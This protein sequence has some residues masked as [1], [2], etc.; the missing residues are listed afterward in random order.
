MRTLKIALVITFFLAALTPAISTRVA[1]LTAT[2]A[3]NQT[4]KEKSDKNKGAAQS[5]QAQRT[6]LPQLPQRPDDH[7]HARRQPGRQPD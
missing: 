3:Q 1:A 6:T 7:F 2:V 5:K 4:S